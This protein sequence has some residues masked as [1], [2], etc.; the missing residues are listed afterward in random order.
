MSQE[1]TVPTRIAPLSSIDLGRLQNGD[2]D[3][4]QRL[5]KACRQ[6]GFFYLDLTCDETLIRD[7]RSLLDLMT[8]YFN[9]PLEDKMR[10]SRS[11]DTHG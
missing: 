6:H 8:K 7:W 5:L 3:E 11:S 9:L 4:T 2:A 10:H 1:N